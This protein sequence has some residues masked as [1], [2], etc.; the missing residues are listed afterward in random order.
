M[1]VHFNCRC[2]ERRKPVPERDWTVSNY[3]WNN[4]AFTP[5]GGQAS[6]WSTVICN[7][8]GAAGRSQSNYVEEVYFHQRNKEKVAEH[9]KTKLSK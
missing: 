7:K 2:E 4:G 8:C 9:E 1:G 6:N 5:Q 3:H